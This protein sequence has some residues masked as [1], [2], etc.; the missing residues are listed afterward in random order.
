MRKNLLKFCLL[1]CIALFSVACSRSERLRGNQFLIEGEVS[2]V[3]DGTVLEFYRTKDNLRYGIVNEDRTTDTVKDGR[4]RFKDEARLNPERILIRPLGASADGFAPMSLEFWVEP[5]SKT[6]IR[7]NDKILLL[8]EVKSS[9]PIQKEANRYT[10]KNRDLIAEWSRLWIEAGDLIIKGRST[11]SEEEAIAYRKDRDSTLAIIRP[12]EEKQ[13]FNNA[14]I[15]EQTNISDVWLHKMA[16]IAHQLNL[17]A[18]LSYATVAL[19]QAFELRKKAEALYDRMSED[20]KNTPMG[21]YITAQLYPPALVKVGDD[22][23]DGD[24][25]DVDGNT[26]R[27]SDYSEPG[28]YLLLDFWFRGCGACVQ[29][30]PEMREI[31][32]TYRNKL[33]IINI[34]TDNDDNW[35]KAMTEHDMPWVNIRDPRG[36]AGLAAD[37]GILGAPSFVLISPESKI[38]DKWVGYGTGYLKQKVGENIK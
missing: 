27:I 34:N 12:L 33:T 9:V 36:F 32:E 28:K 5:K 29:S 6:K 25:L 3:E 24:F 11:A 16:E 8:W 31:S 30:L 15:M 19:E 37:Y 14:A 38:A 23:I 17:A 7:G 2:G 22:F 1:V 26:K 21:K 18:R 35:K 13:L 4:F 10:E 20:D